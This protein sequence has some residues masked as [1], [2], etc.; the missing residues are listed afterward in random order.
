MTI[1][2]VLVGI[3]EKFFHRATIAAHGSEGVKVE[4]PMGASIICIESQMVACTRLHHVYHVFYH[5]A[6]YDPVYK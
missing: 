6:S 2:L 3:F 1:S 4:L 5:F